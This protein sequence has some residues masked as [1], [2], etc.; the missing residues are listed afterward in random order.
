MSLKREKPEIDDFEE[1][2]KFGS[3]EKL[4]NF[5]S[6]YFKKIFLTVFNGYPCKNFTKY[7]CILLVSEPSEPFFILRKKLHFLAAGGVD[8]LPNSYPYF[9]L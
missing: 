4:L 6:Q 3:K 5:Q 1:E 2:E 9:S 8:G 7:F